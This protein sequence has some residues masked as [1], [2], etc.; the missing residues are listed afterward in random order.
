M[1]N[2]YRKF[3]QLNPVI[4]P[5]QGITFQNFMILVAGVR[6]PL[7]DIEAAWDVCMDERE[8]NPNPE[9]T[10]LAQA[11]LYLADVYQEIVVLSRLD[12]KIL[13]MIYAML[14]N[15]LAQETT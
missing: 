8:N 6:V 11:L 5:G 13:P 9:L 4:V 15:K 3:E 1:K 10:F 14:N 2:G 7:T 12:T